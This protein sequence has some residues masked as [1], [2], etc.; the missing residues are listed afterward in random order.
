MSVTGVPP[1]ATMSVA[2]QEDVEIGMRRLPVDFGRMRQENREGVVRD[3]L[4]RLLD[5]IHAVEMRVVDASKMNG[6][7][8]ALDLLLFIE[9]HLDSHLFE[10]GHH[11]DRVVIAEHAIDWTVEVFAEPPDTG[12]RLGVRTKGLAPIIAGEHADV[13]ARRAQQLGHAVMAASLIST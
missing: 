2:S 5:I 10:R 3:A 4:R 11:A 12:D 9:Q 7:A 1:G 6:R 13:V 8:S